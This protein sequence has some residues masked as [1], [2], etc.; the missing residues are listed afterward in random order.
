MTYL[1]IF[2]ILLI[3]A[4]L[5]IQFSDKLSQQV[6]MIP[7][8]LI[9]IALAGLRYETGG[10]WDNYTTL[11][12]YFPAFEQIIGHPEL[13]ISDY[14]EEGFV[15]LSSIIKSLTHNVQYLF[16]TVSA[17][18]ITLIASALPKYTRYPVFGLLCYYCILYFNLEFIYI[19]QATAVALCFYAL[20]YVED[21]KIIPYMLFVLAACTFHRVALVMVPCYFILSKRL[22]TWVYL[23]IIGVGAFIMISGVSWIK[24]IFLTVSSWL[25]TKYMDKAQVYTTSSIFSVERTISVGFIL[26]L[27]IFGG[28]LVFLD[29]ICSHRYGTTHFNMYAMSLFLYYYCYEL[30][31]VSNRLRLFFWIS[32]IVVL[33]LLLEA[34]PTVMDRLI[35]FAVIVVYSFSFSM[36]IFREMPQAIAFTPYQ[37]YIDF[38]RDPRPSTGKERLEKSHEYF[39]QDRKR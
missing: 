29:S 26:N 27:V 15:L 39:R 5:N 23:V 8:A 13:L 1:Q 37:N 6:L 14:A 11:F 12:Y 24:D 10:D 32:V 31:E 20:Q 28:V 34:L 19:R 33:P 18:N 17:I 9:L 30:I 4:I 25:G 22:P 35:T 21:K 38:Q 16:L 3:L 7:S 36:P 2:I